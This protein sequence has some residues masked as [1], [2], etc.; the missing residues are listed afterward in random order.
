MSTYQR[1]VNFGGDGE[2]PG[3]L[4]QQRPFSRGSNWRW[5]DD[6]T[7]SELP[8][9]GIP[10]LICP[11]NAVPLPD[12]CADEVIVNNTPVDTNHPFYGPGVQSTEMRRILKPGGVEKRDGVVYY[13]KP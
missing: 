7:G 8:P 13:T 9:A 1:V 3:A 10:F 6:P 12:N 5:Q 4:N 11:N 2:E